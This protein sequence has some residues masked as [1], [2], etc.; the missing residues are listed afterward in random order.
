MKAEKEQPDA[1]SKELGDKQYLLKRNVL[2]Y[3]KMGLNANEIG[4]LLD[5]S[6]RTVQRYLKMDETTQTAQ[7]K[8]KAVQMS[9]AGYTYK[10]IGDTLGVSKTA[11]YLW[12]REYK[13]QEQIKNT[14]SCK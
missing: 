8:E 9:K 4:K 14:E 12:M 13:D 11:V 7:R 1:Q 10:Q 2:K 6:P 5:I 3:A